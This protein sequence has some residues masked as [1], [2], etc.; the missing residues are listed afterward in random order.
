[1][2]REEEVQIIMTAEDAAAH[3]RTRAEGG[4]DRCEDQEALVA[5]MPEYTAHFGGP[6]SLFLF[7]EGYKRGAEVLRAAVKDNRQ[8]GAGL[9]PHIDI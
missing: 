1:M 2:T 5:V 7:P 6:S 3:A 4:A 8:L 9:P